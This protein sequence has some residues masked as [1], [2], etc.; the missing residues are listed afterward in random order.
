MKYILFILLAISLLSC[1]SK[2]FSHVYLVKNILNYDHIAHGPISSITQK[3]TIT[4]TDSLANLFKKFPQLPCCDYENSIYYRKF[5]SLGRYFKSYSSINKEIYNSIPNTVPGGVFYNRFSIDNKLAKFNLASS[6]HK[7]IITPIAVISNRRAVRH[8][9]YNNFKRGINDINDSTYVANYEHTYLYD[10]DEHNLI[11]KRMYIIY[12][13]NSNDYDNNF[14][15]VVEF[16]YDDKNRINEEYYTFYV[17]L[18]DDSSLKHN[19]KVPIFK[20]NK[21]YY[22]LRIDGRRGSLT[23]RYNYNDA[24]Q[25]INTRLYSG[26]RFMFEEFYEY[27]EDGTLKKR[28]Q[29]IENPKYSTRVR[30]HKVIFTYD[31][32]GNCTHMQQFNRKDEL[33]QQQ[34]VDY[35]GFDHYNNWTQCEFYLNGVH[36][37]RPEIT[38]YRKYT[39]Y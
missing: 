1:K 13:H 36:E 19:M 33:I 22:G 29:L 32:F 4:G 27:N 23:I 25:V 16:K 35:S 6:Y 8:L 39:Y 3:S 17:E 11:E 9:G 14:E 5:D 21:W 37:G 15:E 12:Y 10:L 38:M 31:E 7:D 20:E 24:D 26:E 2:D 28:T 30:S 18:D 34:W